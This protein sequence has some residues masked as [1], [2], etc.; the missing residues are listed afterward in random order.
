MKA[1][2]QYFPVVLFMM[3]FKA[4]LPCETVDKKKQLKINTIEQ[5][6]PSCGTQVCHSGTK[7]SSF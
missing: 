1:T 6:F 5:Y 7:R 3:L 4:V 2:E